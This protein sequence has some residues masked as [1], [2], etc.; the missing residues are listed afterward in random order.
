MS[1]LLPFL[2]ATALIAGL[3]LLR[4]FAERRAGVAQLNIHYLRPVTGDRIEVTAKPVRVGHNL[5]FA[6]AKL[7][8]DKGRVCA[9]CDGIVAV[10]G[11][12]DGA[13]REAV[14]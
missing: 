3:I 9:T 14:I 1:L 10:S 6:E 7:Q 13:R 2:I 5:I 4:M 12:L 11:K 8:D